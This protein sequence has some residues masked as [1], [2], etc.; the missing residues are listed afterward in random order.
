MS[1]E[2]IPQEGV[3]ETP[4]EKIESMFKPEQVEADID[5]AIAEIKK[6]RSGLFRNSFKRENE[7]EII[8]EI[9]DVIA[10]K[11]SINQD[12]VLNNTPEVDEESDEEEIAEHARQ[13]IE[14]N[15]ATDFVLTY[16][17]K[18]IA[19]ALEKYW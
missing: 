2:E 10:E 19:E 4:E 5:N 6:K 14:T 13:T 17:N 16:T 11:Y 1:F 9:M 3:E 12:M 15:R 18:K 7:E 8:G